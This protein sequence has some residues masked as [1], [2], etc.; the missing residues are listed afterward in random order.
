MLSFKQQVFQSIHIK[1]DDNMKKI[2]LFLLLIAFISG[3]GN[4]S[5][6]EEPAG[7]N[8]SSETAEDS[9]D[10]E[11]STK[12]EAMPFDA[13]LETVEVP[14]KEMILPNL[15][16]MST[17]EIITHYRSELEVPEDWI[18]V[19]YT[20][21]ITDE[22]YH[23]NETE[24]MT[25][26]STTKVLL[27][28]LYFDLVESEMLNMDTYIPYYDGG[29]EEG[30]GNITADVVNGVGQNSYSLDYTIQ[31]MIIR[32]DNTATNML[33][34]FYTDN[35]GPLGEGMRSVVPDSDYTA[36]MLEQNTTSAALL[37]ETLLALLENDAY[38]PI[39]E[40]MRSADENLYFKYYIE[41]DMP[42]K[43]GLLYELKHHTGIYEIDGEPVYTLII[44]T[45]NLGHEQAN[46]FFGGIN[47]QLAVR[48][49]YQY[50]VNNL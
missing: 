17:E 27:A 7:S 35:F 24:V 34:R 14:Y 25:A 40:H 20:D 46:E 19:A 1:D 12:E 28:M 9:N 21:L 26:A 38:A 44:L 47:L 3:C 42:V 11:E 15:D 41:E 30:G 5:N 6:D 4:T 39:I 23:H 33:R 32:S 50:Y 2:G 49:Q 10:E 22:T 37:E 48:A 45:S 8:E 18:S 31:E 13:W 36:K 43:Y 16:E 29:F